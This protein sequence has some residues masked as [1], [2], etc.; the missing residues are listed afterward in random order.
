VSTR[1]TKCS[2]ETEARCAGGVAKPSINRDSL[3]DPRTRGP[4]RR[5]RRA[6]VQHPRLRARQAPAFVGAWKQGISIYGWAP[7]RDAGFTDRHPEL[8]TGRGTIQL[9]P[10]QAVEISDDELRDLVLAALD[11]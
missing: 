2:C 6:R 8:I 1:G 11:S 10:E 5:R 7:G 4:S 9:R 3:V